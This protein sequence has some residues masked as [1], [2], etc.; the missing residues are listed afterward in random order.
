ML[1]VVVVAAAVVVVVLVVAGYFRNQAKEDVL[2][3]A[4]GRY[5]GEE[6]C[7]RNFGGEKL[8]KETLGRKL[9]YTQNNINMGL[10]ERGG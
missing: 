7:I 8:R 4:C 1:V 10:K 6:K 2:D 5:W 3:V 9:T